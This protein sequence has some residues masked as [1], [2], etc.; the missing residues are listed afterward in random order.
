MPVAET[1]P[2]PDHFLLKK[3]L[4]TELPSSI[5]L[6]FLMWVQ[7]E[8]KSTT[9]T[10]MFLLRI[11]IHELLFPYVS[12][13]FKLNIMPYMQTWVWLPLRQITKHNNVTCFAVKWCVW[14]WCKEIWS[15]TIQANLVE[16][17]SKLTQT[18][19]NGHTCSPCK[20]CWQGWILSY[21]C[22]SDTLAIWITEFGCCVSVPQEGIMKVGEVSD[23][24]SVS[25][26]SFP[27]VPASAKSTPRFGN[28]WSRQAPST[29]G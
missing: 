28:N 25:H 15:M 2:E 22:K 13:P 7:V 4:T 16:I 17:K 8:I 27:G 26:M 11:W 9:M 5:H 1:V 14:E 19:Q 21:I 18:L 20:C 3:S 6:N 29:T 12:F 24:L 10:Y 23:G